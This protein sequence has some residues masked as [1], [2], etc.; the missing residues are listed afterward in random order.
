M[1][2]RTVHIKM[3]DGIYRIIIPGYAKI[4][5]LEDGTLV[6]LGKPMIDVVIGEDRAAVIDTGYGELDLKSYIEKNITDKPIVCLNTH[7]HVDHIG[8]NSQF[9]EA[10]IG[11]RDI[12]LAEATY[13]Q[14]ESRMCDEVRS[15]PKPKYRPLYGGEIFDLG[16]RTLRVVPI[17]GHSFGSMGYIDSRTKVLFSGDAVLK[18]IIVNDSDGKFVKQSLLNLKKEDFLEILCG[19]WIWPLGRDQVDRFINLID[20]GSS[21]ELTTLVN[22]FGDRVVNSYMINTGKD[23]YDP[24]F[25]AIAFMDPDKFFAGKFELGDKTSPVMMGKKD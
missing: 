21:R 22:N 14:L 20:T 16:G 9:G 23:F 1:A 24:E 18:R 17:P 12:P 25:C 8:G 5:G 19:H 7:G 4:S 15:C 2:E 3:Y 11:W 13:A 10:W 6:G